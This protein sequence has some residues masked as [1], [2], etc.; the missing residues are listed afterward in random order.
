MKKWRALPSCMQVVL[1]EQCRVA[2]IKPE[3]VPWHEEGWY[4]AHTWSAVQE[5]EFEAWLANLFHTDHEIRTE[6]LGWKRSNVRRAKAA[7][8]E[9]VFVYGWSVHG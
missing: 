3:N 1:K 6:L 4:R 7:A 2:G 9:W 8:A 5:S